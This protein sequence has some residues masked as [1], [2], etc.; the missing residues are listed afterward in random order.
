MKGWYS[1]PGKPELVCAFQQFWK[2]LKINYYHQMFLQIYMFKCFL[3]TS[4]SQASSYKDVSNK[5][6]SNKQQK[7]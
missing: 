5:D 7:I 6:V 2:N 4:I 3:S 1:Q